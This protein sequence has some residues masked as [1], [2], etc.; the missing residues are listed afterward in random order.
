MAPACRVQDR[1]ETVKESDEPGE[2]E[3]AQNELLKD[4]AQKPSV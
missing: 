4:N 2:A 1:Q 3:V